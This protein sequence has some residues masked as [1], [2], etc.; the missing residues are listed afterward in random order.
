MNK[1]QRVYVLVE[2]LNFEGMYQTCNI[3]KIY[4]IEMDAL[5][6]K[7]RLESSNTMNDVTY[8]VLK[9]KIQGTMTHEAV[10]MDTNNQFTVITYHKDK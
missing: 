8:H 10:D 4:A 3:L 7:E 2:Y 1:K 9:F 5:K 6:A